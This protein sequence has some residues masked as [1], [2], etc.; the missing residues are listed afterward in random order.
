M[1]HVKLEDASYACI[2]IDLCIFS[3]LAEMTAR[4]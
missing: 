4:E 1:P 3:L 2:D